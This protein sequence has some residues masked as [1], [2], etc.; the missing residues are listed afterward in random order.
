MHKKK[1]GARVLHDG[2]GLLSPGSVFAYAA[3]ELIRLLFVI[4][5]TF[6]PDVTLLFLQRFSSARGRGMFHECQPS[7]TLGCQ[8][9]FLF[10]NSGFPRGAAGSW[11]VLFAVGSE[12]EC[13]ARE[14]PG[15]RPPSFLL[16]RDLFILWPDMGARER[17]L[18]FIFY[19]QFMKRQTRARAPLVD[20]LTLIL[21]Y[22]PA[23]A[24]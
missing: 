17:I 16:P 13:R 9:V 24:V 5:S 21:V 18:L 22:R 11:T 14:R 2:C 15:T 10:F 1:T 4:R 20:V 23:C 6:C 7:V 3:R 8:K 19:F 12:R